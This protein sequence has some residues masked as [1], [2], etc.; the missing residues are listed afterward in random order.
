MGADDPLDVAEELVDPERRL[1]GE[2]ES[3]S[4]P[5]LEDAVHWQRVYEELLAFKRTLLRTAEVHKEAAPAPV[6]HEVG[7]DQVILRSELNRL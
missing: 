2:Q 3:E 4:S 1:P 7:S 5:L 6:V